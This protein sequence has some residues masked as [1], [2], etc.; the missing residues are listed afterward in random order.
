MNPDGAAYVCRNGAYSG[1]RSLAERL[2]VIQLPKLPKMLLK[3]KT[4]N[5]V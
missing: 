4:I 1:G 3:K 5:A 2:T